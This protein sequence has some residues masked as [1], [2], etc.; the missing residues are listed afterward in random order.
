MQDATSFAEKNNI[1]QIEITK[2][3]NDKASKQQKYDALELMLDVMTSDSDASAEEMS[4][5]DDVVKLLN[6]DPTTYKE[7]RQSRLTKVEN[8]STN[9][10]ADESIFGIETTMSNE[11]IC[12]KLAD[13]YEEWSQRLALPDKAMSKR[14]KEMCDKI[15]ELRKKYKCS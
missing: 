6:L 15:I 11:Q 4:I 12:S 14:A 2:E 1:S 5:I 9:E 10:T 8:I 3:I 13:Q 7:L